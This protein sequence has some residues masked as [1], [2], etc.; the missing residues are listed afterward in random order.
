MPRGGKRR[1]R[2][3][4][5]PSRRARTSKAGRG[6]HR[7][8]GGGSHRR[9]QA[10]EAEGA[11]RLEGRLL[12]RVA[13]RRLQA[14]AARLHAGRRPLLPVRGRRYR[15]RQ[16]LPSPRPSDLRGHGLQVLRASASCPTSGWRHDGAPGRATWTSPTS[17]GRRC[18][19]ASSRSRSASSGCSR[20]PTSSSS[21]A[22]SRR[23]SPPT[24]TSAS[25]SPAT[26]PTAPSSYQVG[27]F[28]GLFDGGSNNDDDRNSDKDFAGRVFA[29][30]VQDHGHRSRSQSLGFGL[31][32]TFGN[33]HRRQLGREL[34]H[35]RALDLL[36]LRHRRQRRR[37]GQRSGASVPQGYW[38]WGP[39][40]LMGEYIYTESGV[41]GT[42]GT[43]DAAT[44]ASARR[45][46]RRLVRAGL[47]GHHRRGGD[48]QGA[49]TDQPVR[50][51]QRSLGRLRDRRRASATSSSTTTPS[52]PGSRPAAT[53]RGPTPRASTGTSTGTSSCSSTTSGR[54]ST[55]SRRSRAS[56]ATTRTC[57]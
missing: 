53:R 1:E 7:Q 14:E 36:P 4:P 26:S 28:N 52:T 39:F 22:R 15:Q 43:G 47:L 46:D 29:Q 38:Y 48:L 18:A 42:V 31:A 40:G 37:Q 55:A 35:R 32:G 50:S 33:R 21:S 11:R 5:P 34:P 30:P 20:A 13:E 45:E 56:S 2:S 57:C 27:I 19:P 6:G 44:T 8:A 49:V 10:Q 51:T 12:P 54:T 16:L 23:T 41:K 9:R 25:S 3:R 17:P 24:A